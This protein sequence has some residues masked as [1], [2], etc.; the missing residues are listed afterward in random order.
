MRVICRVS[1]VLVLIFILSFATSLPAGAGSNSLADTGAAVFTGIS[2][3]PNIETIGV[4]VSGT[5]FSSTAALSYRRSGET[6][7]H[8]GQPLMPIDDGRLAGSLFNLSPATSY[9]VKV[10]DGSSQI[11]GSVSTQPDGLSF[12]PSV[13]LHVNDDASPGGDGS[14]AAPFRT[15]QEAVNHAGPGTQ[16]LVA[17]GMYR[18]AVTFPG[19]GTA[20]NW[21]QVKA[22][23]NAAILDSA[24]VLS[25]NIWTPSTTSH[26]WYRSMSGPV[27]YL[28]REWES[29]LSVRRSEWADAGDRSWR[30]RHQRGLV[31]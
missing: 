2:F 10:L 31:L 12:T 28:A 6:L 15:I 22:E 16:V 26:V 1:S 3:V 7:W 17:D 20:G 18:E 29:F 11:S 8:S 23:G 24:D 21:I 14:A 9:D 19:S 13:I 4:V 5:G 27:A 25:G 30:D